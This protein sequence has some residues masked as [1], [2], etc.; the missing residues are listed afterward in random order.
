L[1]HKRAQARQMSFQQGVHGDAVALASAL[2]E[3][4]RVV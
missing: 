1:V 4:L 2:N 3:L